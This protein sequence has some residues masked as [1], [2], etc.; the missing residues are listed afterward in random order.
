M[1]IETAWCDGMEQIPAT[2]C[3]C[4]FDGR[5]NDIANHRC[6]YCAEK[7]I[8]IAWCNGMGRISATLCGFGG[9][10]AEITNQHC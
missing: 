9:G 5:T 1:P 2:S 4:G 10:T 3:R 6:Q 8:E 7:P